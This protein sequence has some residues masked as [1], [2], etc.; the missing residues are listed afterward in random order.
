VEAI[1]DEGLT[2]SIQE[3]ADGNGVVLALGINDSGFE[4]LILVG[5]RS[6]AHVF[7]AQVLDVGVDV[8]SSKLLGERDL[9]QRHLVDAGA[10]RAQQRR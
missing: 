8:G 7:L 6:D 2:L 1:L 10:R 4:H 3:V 9:L 5:L